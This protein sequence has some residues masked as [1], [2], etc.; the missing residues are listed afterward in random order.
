MS[1]VLEIDGL[2]Y[3]LSAKL[4]DG[5]LMLGLRITG[6]YGND[7]ETYYPTSECTEVEQVVPT[8]SLS[9]FTPAQ[10]VLNAVYPVR[11][12]QLP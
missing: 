9:E 3:A 12:E 7:G 10:E 6:A 1:R 4:T 5:T 11:L 2:L 8:Y